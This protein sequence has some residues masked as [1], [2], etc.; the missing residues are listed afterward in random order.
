M[1]VTTAAITAVRLFTL[2]NEIDLKLAEAL[3]A[4]ADRTASSRVR[5]DAVPATAISFA[6]AP[7]ELAF[8][9]VTATVDG[10]TVELQASARLYDFGVV[11]VALRLA[12]GDMPWPKFCERVDKLDAAIGVDGDEDIWMRLRAT[13]ADLVGGAYDRP[14]TDPVVEDYLIAKVEA[15]DRPLTAEALLA[16][17]DIVPLLA[18]HARPLAP[19]TC[20]ELLR[21]RFSYYADDLA[22]I[23]W[24]RAFL[25]EPRG[26]DDIADILEVANAQLVEMRAYDATLNAK[27]PR[28]A[29]LTSDGRHGVG[30]FSARRHARHARRLRAL[31]AE[32][33]ELTERVENA[34]LVTEDV[35]LARVY[36]AAIETF[37]VPKVGD[38]VDRK[39][40]IIRETF[41]SLH[42]E[43]Q[44]ARGELLEITVIL[45]IALE[46]LLSVWRH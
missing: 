19:A 43:A 16:E 5:L 11:A 39:L 28:L 1:H 25:Y 9:M 33:T 26:D 8:G 18:G 3:W 20:A 24:D 27:L 37:R 30:P 17:A 36:A 35:Y 23:T 12:V 34:L 31:V 44:N 29:A 15:F 41:A 22:V 6:V 38:A 40:A 42:E 32:I 46:V 7:L 14:I 2:A 10:E 21:Q 13:L 4:G 45:L